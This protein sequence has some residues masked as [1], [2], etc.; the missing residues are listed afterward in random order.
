MLL[1]HG[2]NVSKGRDQWTALMWACGGPDPVPVVKIFL[3]DFKVDPNLRAD[4]VRLVVRILYVP[5]RFLRSS[6]KVPSIFPQSFFPQGSLNFPSMFPQYPL[7]LSSM[8]PQGFLNVRW[9]FPERSPGPDCGDGGGVSRP[10]SA[11]GS[12]YSLNGP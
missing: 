5:S 10:A 6:L 4:K 7:R 1:R 3:H 2:A 12:E 8:F 11:G 9:T